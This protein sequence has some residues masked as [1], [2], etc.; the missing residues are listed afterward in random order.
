MSRR[1]RKWVCG[2]VLK[3]AR[4]HVY[5]PGIVSNTFASEVRATVNPASAIMTLT[6]NV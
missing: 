3:F 6:K 5:H 2:V 1:I 4:S